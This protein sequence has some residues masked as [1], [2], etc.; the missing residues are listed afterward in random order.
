MRTSDAE[1]NQIPAARTVQRANS[2]T[3]FGVECGAARFWFIE[4]ATVHC[5]GTND[6]DGNP[7]CGS[8][9]VQRML[10]V[11]LS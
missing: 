5:C 9:G 10:H 8:A 3:K 11:G 6:A 4:S 1:C 2:A 7:S